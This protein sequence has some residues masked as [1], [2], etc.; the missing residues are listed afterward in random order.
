MA[1]RAKLLPPGRETSFNLFEVVNNN[2]DA[3]RWVEM[4]SL[5]GDEK[6]G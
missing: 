3:Y 4:K 1:V 6:F 2:A 5:G